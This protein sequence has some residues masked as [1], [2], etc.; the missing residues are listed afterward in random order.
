MTSFFEA[1]F[2]G[3]HAASADR[4]EPYDSGTPFVSDE[5]SALQFLEG[6]PGLQPDKQEALEQPFTLQELEQAVQG[7]GNY[8]STGLDGLSYKFYKRTFASTGPHLL[9]A[10]NEMLRQEQLTELLRRGVVRLLP[11]VPGVPKVEQLTPI[12][13]LSVDYKLLTKMLVARLVKVLP[14][15]ITSSQLCS[16]K[17]RSI[18]DGSAAV[19]S[20]ADN[21]AAMGRPGFLVSLDLFLAY[22]RV[23]LPWVDRILEAMGFGPKL[24]RVIWTLHKGA[25]ATFMLHG[26]SPDVAILF[27][28]RQD[29]PVAM[30]WYVIQIEPLL[31]RLG[32]VLQVLHGLR[33]G[34]VLETALGYVDD[35][36]T[37][38]DTDQDLVVFDE[39]MAAFERASG[40]ILNRNR[41]SVVV[42]L[43]TWESR[44]DWPI[45]WL[46][47]PRGQALRSDCDGL[48][49][50]NNGQDLGQGCWRSGASP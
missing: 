31:F 32:R 22:N 26:L 28:I 46:R 34:P 45:P 10:L 29:N 33:V 12:T 47:D 23:S 44:E 35:V 14:T 4:P 41:K 40:A 17:G 50:E 13:L 18:F 1:L 25:M 7:A 42:G 43:G 15:V 21:L 19:L 6:L 39:I 3:R 16:V 8:K 37:L 20:A 27:S 2:Q 5:C 49:P 24:R 36:A 30:I 9:E 38:G 48:S 11:K